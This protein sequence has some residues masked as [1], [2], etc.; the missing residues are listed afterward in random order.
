MPVLR[1]EAAQGAGVEELLEKLSEHRAYIEAEGTLSERR[2]RNL[3]SE[4][5]AIASYR[6]RRELEAAIADDP[7]VAEL[8]DRVARRELDPATAAGAILASRGTILASR[9]NQV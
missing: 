6:M 5:V 4:A 7:A 2:G 9:G 8:L 3:R 1:T